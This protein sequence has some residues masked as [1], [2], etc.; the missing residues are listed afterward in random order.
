MP[1]SDLFFVTGCRFYNFNDGNAALS[2]CFRCG[3]CVILDSG[4]RETRFSDIHMDD[5][6][7]KVISWGNHN[8]GYFKDL[9]GTLTGRGPNSFVTSYAK[10]NDWP[11]CDGFEDRFSGIV[12]P[13]PMVIKRIAFFGASGNAA[14]QT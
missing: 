7:T 5:T 11:E 1:Q 8:K 3:S 6:V 4:T 10:H 2:E 9:D 13:A 14:G 12:C